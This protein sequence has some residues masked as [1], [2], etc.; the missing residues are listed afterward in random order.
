MALPGNLKTSGIHNQFGIKGYAQDPKVT[1]G[2]VATINCMEAFFGCVE[3]DLICLAPAVQGAL[4]LAQLR[5]NL[6]V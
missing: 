5:R 4:A 1:D 2:R 3:A 6:I